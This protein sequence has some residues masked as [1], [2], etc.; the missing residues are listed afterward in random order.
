MLTM[1]FFHVEL[2]Q[3][4]LE[5]NWHIN[6]LELL[7]IMV[8]IQVWGLQLKGARFRMKWDNTVA[9]SPMNMKRTHNKVA[10]AIM[11]EIAY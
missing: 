6:V 8:A 11:C 3:L 9:E 5:Q 1:N 10:Q 4:I 7:V 2:P